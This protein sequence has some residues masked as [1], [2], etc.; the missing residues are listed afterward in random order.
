MKKFVG[1][2]VE[3][4]I[5]IISSVDFSNQSQHQENSLQLELDEFVKLLDENIEKTITKQAFSKARNISPKAFETLFL[6]TAGEAL[7][8]NAFKCFKDY[9]CC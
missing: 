3:N 5:E 1:L 6:M 8:N 7:N 4:T 2:L 9:C